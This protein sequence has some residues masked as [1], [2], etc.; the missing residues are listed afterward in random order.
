MEEYK[1][2][3]PDIDGLLRYFDRGHQNPSAPT[4]GMISAMEPLFSAL[5]DLAPLT[6]NREVKSI[7]LQIPRGSIDDYDSYED[8]LEWEEVRNMEEY[9]QRWLQDYP[10]EICWYELIVVESFDKDG[11][12][13]F[14]G[15]ALDN[16]TI[17]S[18]MMNQEE[19]SEGGYE[20]D[21]AITLCSLLTAAAKEAMTRI[22]K[23][24]YNAEVNA[25]LPY[26]FRTG[27][28]RR[29]V[30]WQREPEWKEQAMEGLSAETLRSFKNLLAS[31]ENSK[32]AIGRL[33]AMTANDFFRACSTGYKA[34]GYK[35]LT[36][37]NGMELPLVDQ[38]FSHADG[39]DEGL[40]GRGHGLNAGPGIDFDDADA[41]AKWYFDR[42]QHGGHPW[43][44]CAGGN[45]THVDLFVYHDLHMLDFNLRTGKIT[46]DEYMRGAEHAGYYF[47]V[48]GKHR[49]AEAVN[50]YIAL[51]DAGF[52]VLLDDADE[53]LARFEGTDYV[54]IVPQAVTPKYC[55]NLFPA[56]YGRVI[57]FMN[58]YSEEMAQFGD[59]IE[60][61]P[62]ERAEL[63]D[64]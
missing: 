58:I 9:E 18:A 45:S 25:A 27:V 64:E 8:M 28:I 38:Y 1:L 48:A 32:S 20:E 29:S 60:W 56:K 30:L 43:E 17:I 47:I 54:G 62:E 59:Q 4:A 61:I 34:C 49:A 31:G 53:I 23:G 44:V 26:Q 7:W 35:G 46:E 55:E 41:W 36:D 16:K 63:K 52:P 40:S 10:Q 33:K 24:T 3:A 57:D 14:R 42:E 37:R 6:K 22:R 2:V 13:R 39:R 5:S 51:H 12:I 11:N 21:A 50:F 19:P 15:V